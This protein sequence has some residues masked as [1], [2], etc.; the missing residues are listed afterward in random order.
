MQYRKFGNHGF[1]ASLLGFGCMR[2]PV[3]DGDDSKI[4]EVQATAML[5]KAVDMGVNYVDTAYPYHKGSSE[6]FVGRALKDGYR[7]KVYLATKL[8]VWLVED[9]HD[10][11][12]YLK[13]QL[14]RLD[15]DWIDCYLLHSLNQSVW[16]KIKTLG[17]FDF[18][19]KAKADG[20]IRYAG[21]SFHDDLSVFKEIIDAYPWDFCQIQLNYTDTHYQAGLEGL[22]YAAAKGIPVI[23]MEPLKGGRL[24]SNPPK[25]VLALWH[26]A[27]IPRTPADWA[28]RW[29]CNFPEVT[30]V[31]SGMGT[32]EQLLQNIETVE[33]ALPESLTDEEQKTIE[34]VKRKYQEMIKIQCTGCGYCM[35]CAIGVDIPRNFTLY[36]DIF[37]YNLL[38]PSKYTYNTWLDD[39][40][41]AS[42]CIACG[43]CMTVCPQNLNIIEYLKEVHQALGK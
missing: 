11:D 21:F 37:M 9:A 5:R 36:N 25:E 4:D 31:L 17:V 39:E 14:Q 2:L 38:D 24:T 10:F 20:H 42:A 3:L 13:E 40:E 18:L 12:K 32:M 29:V 43:K 8:P 28:L 6:P 34:Q 23:V 33:T 30:V 22:K 27:S 16:N 26:Q 1:K 19:E 15:T 7:E 35:P 41:K